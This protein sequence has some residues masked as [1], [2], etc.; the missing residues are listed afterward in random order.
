[1]I[2]T[3]CAEVGTT[4]KQRMLS[5]GI[6][7]LGEKAMV[8]DPD[9]CS[10]Y[11]SGAQKRGVRPTHV[12]EFNEKRSGHRERQSGDLAFT[13]CDVEVAPYRIEYRY[14]LV[15]YPQFL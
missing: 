13:R 4:W 1:M 5:R 14:G 2:P 15:F 10:F 12:L 6:H 9:T 3:T 11:P 8:G 7:P